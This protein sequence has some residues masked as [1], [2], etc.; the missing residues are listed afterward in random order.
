MK[1]SIAKAVALCVLAGLVIV[2]TPIASAA[3][4]LDN[5][6]RKGNCTDKFATAFKSDKDTTV[7]FVE[8]FKQGDPVAL[9][10]STTSLPAPVDVCLVKLS[11]APA[12][13]AQRELPRP[14]PASASSSGCPTPTFGTSVFATT[15][16]AVMPV[17]IMPTLLGLATTVRPTPFTWPPS[18]KV[19]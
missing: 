16:A 13:Q 7:L 19:M 17:A 11:S 5:N 8:E 9:S 6:G 14:R 1:T 18:A 3:P 4:S 15:A 10:N 2:G 12:I